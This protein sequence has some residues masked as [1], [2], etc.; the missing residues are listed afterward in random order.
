MLRFIGKLFK[1]SIYLIVLLGIAAA[2][3]VFFINPD[4]YKAEANQFLQNYTGHSFEISGPITYSVWPNLSVKLQDITLKSPAIQIKH[5]NIHI[6]PYSL[7]GDNL[8]ITNLELSEVTAA[9]DNL[10]LIPA[11]PV[12]SHAKIELLSVKKSTVI[13]KNEQAKQ[14]WELR[15]LSFT[16]KNITLGSDTPLEPISF[17]GSL[18]NL[19]NSATFTIDAVLTADLAKQSLSLKPINI[20]W[21][22]TK[23]QADA[24]VSQYIGNP[25]VAGN[26]TIDQ[27][28]ITELLKKLD[29]YFA[30]SNA[31]I[32]NML[33][34]Q[35][36]YSY[37]MQDELLDL[38]KI[39]LKLDDGSL[40]GN[41]KLKLSSPYK[42]EFNLN[43]DKLDFEPMM[44]L[45]KAM[46]PSIPSSDVIP[47]DFLKNIT[48]LGK[49]S[50]LNL[51]LKP[52]FLID[53]LT[54]EITAQDGLVQITPLVLSAYNSKHN[55]E[56]SLDVTKEVSSIKLTQQSDGFAIQPWA[57][58]L[59]LPQILSGDAKLKMSI[60]SIGNT[61]EELKNGISG[62]INLNV[63]NGA[64]YGFDI[65]KLMGY[66]ATTI[67]NAFDQ[68][69]TNKNISLHDLLF[70]K[71]S[72]W[73]DTQKDNPI[74]SFDS[75]EFK[76]D[77][78]QGISQSSSFDLNNAAFELK[79]TGSFDII[80]NQINY[81]GV[82]I[83][84]SD[85]VSHIAEISTVMK[86]TPLN[87]PI[88]GSFA[89]PVI[90]PNIEE[91]ATNV[92]KQTQDV[93]IKKAASSMVLVA[94]ANAK[95][96]KTAEEIFSDSLKGL[97]K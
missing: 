84:K 39:A 87:L 2:A 63:T 23:L 70:P 4:N 44:M 7:L 89:Q 90:A 95:T 52:D 76:A 17:N 38:S 31:E 1:L 80:K 74:S 29:P 75:L 35:I 96:T 26:I 36:A 51:K 34:A 72:K 10:A 47:V 56:L 11:T 55:L 48:I 82:L 81:A 71:V 15:N 54:T 12:K 19:N 33:Q 43:S 27:T 69:P 64:I 61:I 83:N 67:D 92:L 16:T 68:M 37:T 58:L 60:D 62:G 42:V 88:S 79:G 13:I 91:Y 9:V 94:P 21:N 20:I 93:L 77:L 25:S 24:L 57:K 46:F 78:K 28:N 3:V 6:D 73:L 59:N 40:D 66:I 45:G 5:A 30:P 14:N 18:V 49:I 8:T 97:T 22:D 85:T 50:A 41:L 65:S 32:K 86:Y 53:Q